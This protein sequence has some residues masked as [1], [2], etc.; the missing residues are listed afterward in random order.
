MPSELPDRKVRY[1]YIFL[2]ESTFYDA[3]SENYDIVMTFDDSSGVFPVNDEP[4]V[5]VGLVARRKR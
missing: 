5:G 2:Q 3:I 4:I 1:P